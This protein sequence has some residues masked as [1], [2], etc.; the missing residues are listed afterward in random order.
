MYFIKEDRM[1]ECPYDPNGT[2][3]QQYSYLIAI[4]VP[5]LVSSNEA[6]GKTTEKKQADTQ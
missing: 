1:C 5:F 6:N 4:D 3:K 2:K